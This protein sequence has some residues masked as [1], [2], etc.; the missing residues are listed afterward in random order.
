[1]GSPAA[2]A[3]RWLATGLIDAPGVEPPETA[4]EPAPFYE[5]LARRGVETTL[6]EE[7]RLAG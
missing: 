1:V 5:E 4:I 2:I 3:A 6:T 7:T